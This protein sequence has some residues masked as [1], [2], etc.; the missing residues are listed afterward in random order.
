MEGIQVNEG[1]DIEIRD[2]YS[3]AGCVVKK[4]EGAGPYITKFLFFRYNLTPV[5][6]NEDTIYLF[7]NYETI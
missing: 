7:I 2:H 3:G 6:V 5:N 1:Q 4:K